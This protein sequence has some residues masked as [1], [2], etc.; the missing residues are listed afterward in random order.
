MKNF[1]FFIL[2]ISLFL[3]CF[4]MFGQEKTVIRGRITEKSTEES[5][6]GVNIIEMDDQ[7]R[8]VKGVITDINGNYVFEVN[9]AKH[10]ILVSFIGY[11]SQSVNINSRTTIN[12]EL[13]T[14]TTELDQITITAQSQGDD[15]TGVSQRDQT[16]STVKVNM[17]KISGSL[18]VSLAQALQGE[19]SGLD[20]VAS[21]SPGGGSSIVIRGMG[22]LGNANPLVVVD[23]IPQD[24][25]TQ[26]FNFASADEQDLG[27]MLNIAPQDIKSVVVLKDAASTAIW[28]SKGANGVLMIETKTGTRGKIQFTYQY[29]VTANIEPPK[30]PML[31]G[32]E[33]VT[34]QLEEWHNSDAVYNV[35]PEIAYD[36]NYVDFYN[37]SANTNW[38]D[39]ITRNA[40]T[41]DHFFKISGGGQ[42]TRYYTSINYQKELGTTINTSFRRFSY[43]ANFDYIISDNLRLTTNFTY[44]NSLTEQ[45]PTFSKTNPNSTEEDKNN[46]RRMAYIKAPNM[47]IWEHD[48]N[49]NLTGEYFIPIESY[50]GSGTKFFN[51]VAIANL[52]INDVRSNQIQ[53]NFIIDYKIADWLKFK[54]SV[55][56]AYI[57]NKGNRF[58]PNA[59][60]GAA[61]YMNK[62]NEATERNSGDLRWL[63]R[64]QL[65]FLPFQKS[66]T[67]SLTGV[68]MWEM[69][70]KRAEWTQ[71]STNRSASVN[72]S[73]PSSGAPIG[74]VASGSQ[75]K[76]LFGAFSSLNYKYKDRYIA[77]MNLRADGSS[78]FGKNNQWGI[79]PSVSLGWRFSEEPFL[80]SLYFLD[81]SKIR[82][83]WG[84]S[85]RALDNPYASYSYYETTNHYMNNSA[86]VPEQIELTNLKWETASSWNGGLDL[87]M[88]KDRIYITV[89]VY[90]SITKNLLHRNY[91]IPSLSGFSQLDYFN[92]GSIQNIG[93]EFFMRGDIIKKDKLRFALDFNISKN[94]NSFLSFPQNF[95]KERGSTIGN[96]VYPRKAEVGQPI[97]SFYGFR[98]LGVYPSD[99]DAVARDENGIIMRNGN[100]NPIQMSYKEE[101][102]FMGGDAKYEDI[103]H[104]GKIDILDAVY[105]G[106]SSPK[107]IGGFGTNFEYGRFNASV[108]F[109][110]RLGF[111]IMNQVAMDTQGMLNR[112]NQSKAVLRRWQRQGQDE[113]GLLPR[114]YMNHPANNLGSDRYVEKGDYL[115]LN[116]I[117][118]SYNVSSDLAKRLNVSSLNI[119]L[120]IRKLLTITNYSGQDPEI[121]R[122]EKDPFWMGTDDATTPP[123]RE[124][125]MR[126]NINF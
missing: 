10:T 49:G 36:K 1:R 51:P 104:D 50:Q 78:A 121:S 103:N 60:I 30:I 19:V 42:R 75:N 117:D 21:G 111:D 25:Q 105:I 59:A 63:S 94:H 107:V 45:N 126:I 82:L 77:N 55:S 84:Q 5:L 101:Y 119:G 37:Y 17:E 54:E 79:F 16:G 62:S 4:E 28:G 12:I 73:D 122:K 97:G 44:T 86:I 11:K 33:Y 40:F 32:D 15:L 46:I 38:M 22:S 34:M 68:L 115:R 74:A 67:H 113:V 27:Q 88:F 110:Y 72:I 48:E 120:T 41:H 81:D 87:N 65:F 85:G 114:A 47:S 123:S 108:K 14:N 61:W 9:N 53:N 56:F 83:S 92:G 43:R 23:G 90:K 93:W 109:H 100:G 39:E 118:L 26:N 71:L 58:I 24:I 76:R 102:V 13:E 98:Y 35:P 124:Y 89:E 91:K 18:G 3:H 125:S 2:T 66:I 95:L 99:E 70:E 8:V 31:N 64:S 6:P 96:G 112:N 80:K 57:N 29:K 20:I 116:N 69:E 7:N 106:N 52:G